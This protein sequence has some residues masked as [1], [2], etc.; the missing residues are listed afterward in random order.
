MTAGVAQIRPSRAANA[1]EV[2]TAMLEEALILR[3]ENRVDQQRGKIVVADRAAFLT[4]AVE[5][6]SDE[7]RLNFG[8]VDRVAAA[9]RADSANG[10]ARKLHVQR[11]SADKVR[12]LGGA[13]V[14]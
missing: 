3:G 1:H 5:Q 13:N 12:E 8:V 7:L 10:L 14:H 4:Q 6:I 9:E 2:E 11:I